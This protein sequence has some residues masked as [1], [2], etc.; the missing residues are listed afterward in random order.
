[1]STETVVRPQAQKRKSRS[2]LTSPVALDSGQINMDD[3]RRASEERLA[4]MRERIAAAQ[5]WSAGEV[6]KDV[7]SARRFQAAMNEARLAAHMK[8]DD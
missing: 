2:L 3:L 6:A 1:M 7:E 8:I 4:L 5:K